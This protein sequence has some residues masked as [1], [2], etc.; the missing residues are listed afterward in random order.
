MNFFRNLGTR[1]RVFVMTAGLAV[2]LALLFMVV[3]DPMLAHSARLDR[4]IVTAQRELQELQTLQRTYQ[5]QKS[6]LDRI[7][8]QLKRQQNFAL[9]SRLEELAGQAGLRSKIL[10]M[11]PTIGTPSD[12]YDEE[13]VEIKME[14]VTL[15]QLI[16]YLY[17]VE[18]SP[19][20][21]KIKRL[22]IKPRLEN[23]QI[24]SATFRVST[25]TP[26]EGT[27]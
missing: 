8:A 19:Q 6:V 24:L 4:Q 7:N 25:F 2:L 20:F 12:A 11:K 21:M 9:L 10:Y 3:I 26:K 5:R 1:E 23:R 13:A 15:E 27:S 22:Y 17:Q 16:Q 14:G 18:N